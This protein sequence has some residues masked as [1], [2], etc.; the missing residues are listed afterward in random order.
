MVLILGKTIRESSRI[1]AFA[2]FRAGLSTVQLE[3]HPTEERIEASSNRLSC[4]LKLSRRSNEDIAIVSTEDEKE[5]GTLEA[6]LGTK[7]KER[8]GE[9]VGPILGL[10]DGVA[11][12]ESDGKLV[13]DMGI[14]VGL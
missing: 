1:A 5:E 2:S 6:R 9:A 13:V 8:V 7:L 12:G 3:K 11:V 10:P 4:T 14:V